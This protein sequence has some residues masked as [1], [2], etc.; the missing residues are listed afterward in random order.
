MKRKMKKLYHVIKIILITFII[1]INFHNFSFADVVSLVDGSV[2]NGKLIKDSRHE[3]LFVNY[4]GTFRINKTK[5]IKIV[6][7]RSYEEDIKIKKKMGMD[8][9]EEQI[10]RNY[11]AGEAVK[12]NKEHKKIYARISLTGLGIITFGRLNSVLPF[13]FGG[14][15]DYDQNLSIGNEHAYIPWLRFEGSYS[16]YRKKSALVTGYGASG[17]LMWLVPLGPK[18]EARLVLSVLAGM[19]FLDIKKESTN[20]KAKSNTFTAHSI[21]GFEFPF[22]RVALTILGRYTYIYDKTAT[23]HNIGCAI[24]LSFSI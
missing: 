22:G 14:A 23:L 15:L 24:G 20:Y 17:G 1:L 4:Y 3:I 18:Q 10:K 11:Q 2:L 13:G 9:E 19:S 6:E 16:L 8:V 21:A 12:Q 7:T 5:I